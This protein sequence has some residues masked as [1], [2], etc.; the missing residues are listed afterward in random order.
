MVRTSLAA[1]L[2]NQPG[3]DGVTIGSASLELDDQ[4]VAAA[5]GFIPE[6]DAGCVIMDDHDVE[7]AITVEVAAG[8]SATHVKHLEIGAGRGGDVDETAI[9]LVPPKDGR[10]LVL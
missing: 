7:I 8:Q 6:H 4:M 2:G 3:A 9:P 5:G 1:D 10:V